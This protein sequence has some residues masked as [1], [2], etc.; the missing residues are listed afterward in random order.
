MG[1]EMCIRDRLLTLHSSISS[2]DFPLAARTN[3]FLHPHLK[4]PAVLVHPWAHPPLLT[5]HSLISLHD[6]PLAARTNPFLH[7]HLKDPCMHACMRGGWSEECM[8]A[9]VWSVECMHAGD[10]S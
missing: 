4:D 7:P 1:S 3:P 6:F 5:L 10:W 8:Y 2:H 9:G